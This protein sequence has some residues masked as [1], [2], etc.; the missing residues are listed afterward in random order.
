MQPA[1]KPTGLY[2]GYSVLSTVILPLVARN[3]MAKLRDADVVPARTREILGRASA[4]RSAG[5]VIWFQ[6]C[7][8]CH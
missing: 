4:P 6:A 7:R 5:K 2:R 1:V 8:F 3:R